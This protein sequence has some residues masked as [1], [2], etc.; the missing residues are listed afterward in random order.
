MARK[1]LLC[2]P[3][4]GLNDILCRIKLCYDY[5]IKH[6]RIMLLIWPFWEIF[7][8]KP[9]YKKRIITDVNRIRKIMHANKR[10]LY[11]IKHRSVPLVELLVQRPE[12]KHWNKTDL[13][14]KYRH[15]VISYVY[16]G[17]GK[18][19][20]SSISFFRLT[21]RARNYIK[22]RAIKPPYTGIHIRNTDYTSN[23]KTLLDN[24]RNI[25]SKRRIFLATDSYSVKE[26]ALTLNHSIRSYAALNPGD[27][28]IHRGI[29]YGLQQKLEMICDLI[30]L[31]RSSHI[32]KP[33]P[34]YGFTRLALFL[35]SH[36]RVLK[37]LI[38]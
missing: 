12:T 15:P 3:I 2:I 37:M 32:I 5:C 26:Y 29:N 25:I 20:F 24:H 18:G 14:R 36:P 1:Y 22:A 38:G 6:N 21:P 34:Y 31:A 16:Y 23:Y 7:S 27:R 19:S 35:Q 17:G 8:L 28:P 9:Q 11:P 33:L 30:L 4:G 13:K 10:F